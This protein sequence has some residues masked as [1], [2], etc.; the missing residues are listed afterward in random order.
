MADDDSTSGDG[1]AR[2]SRRTTLTGVA[3]ATALVMG[4]GFLVTQGLG[5]A[6][7]F[8]SSPGGLQVRVETGVPAPVEAQVDGRDPDLALWKADDRT[9]VYVSEMAYSSSCPPDGSARLADSGAVTLEIHDFSADGDCTA[10]AGRVTVRI[11]GLTAP[12]SALD[13]TALGQR[14]AVPVTLWTASGR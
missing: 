7:G 9:L 1:T 11:S 8:F 5:G 2:L 14:R 6:G 3:A 4:G 13:V 10:D 12:P